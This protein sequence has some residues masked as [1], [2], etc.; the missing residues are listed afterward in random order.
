M[1]SAVSIT[2]RN[3][4]KGHSYQDEA[5]LR[6]PGVTGTI[7]DGWPKGEG[8]TKWA[9]ETTVDYVLDHFAELVDM[10]PSERRKVLLGARWTATKKAA[11][12][13]TTVHGVADRLIHGEEVP[14]PEGLEGYVRSAVAFLDEWDV[15]PVAVEFTVWSEAWR[16][17]GTCDLIADLTDPND[18]SLTQRW[19]LDYKTKDKD[20]GVFGESIL[21]LAAYGHGEKMMDAD[22]NESPM[23]DVDRYGIVQLRENGTYKLIPVDISGNEYRIFQYVQA[24]GAWK[25]DVARSLVGEALTPPHAMRNYRLVEVADDAWAAQP[26]PPA[27]PAQPGEEP[28]F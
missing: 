18:P 19:L 3:H 7:A 21:Q 6:I 16:W 27:M 15:R 9:V 11:A 20:Q 1:G 2:R 23:L 4:G 14:M 13:G 22:G 10:A 5:G 8:L 26:M 25:E 12:R 28:P 24:V 17:A